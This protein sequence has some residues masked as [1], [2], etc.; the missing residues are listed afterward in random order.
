LHELKSLKQKRKDGKPVTIATIEIK[1][2]LFDIFQVVPGLEK[3]CDTFFQNAVLD[4]HKLVQLQSLEGD[5]ILTG[6][7]KKVVMNR[8]FRGFKAVVTI[9]AEARESDSV[10]FAYLG[11]YIPAQIIALQ[12]ELD[13]EDVVQNKITENLKDIKDLESISLNGK[14]IFHK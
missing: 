8:M 1:E 13:F 10:L 5:E 7:L 2:N 12:T 11:D 9:E 6:H 14:E 4:C 3:F